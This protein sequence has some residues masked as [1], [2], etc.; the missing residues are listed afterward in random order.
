MLFVDDL[1][2]DAIAVIAEHLPR[3]T[4][5]DDDAGVLHVRRA[6]A[7]VDEEATAFGGSRSAAIRCVLHRPHGGRR[8]TSPAEREWLR[9][10]WDALLPHSLARGGYVNSATEFG[11][12]RVRAIYGSKYDRLP[13][14]QG[15]VRPDERVPAQRQHPAH[16]I[17]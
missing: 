3:K 15:A 1:T 7:D 17:V 16:L 4:S 5:A 11:G 12:D 9:T 10:F 6:Y 14:D 8:G 13:Q 2:D